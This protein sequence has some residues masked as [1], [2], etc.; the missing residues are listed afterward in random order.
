MRL[1]MVWFTLMLSRCRSAAVRPGRELSSWAK[2]CLRIETQTN[3]AVEASYSRL[4]YRSH[5]R[6]AYSSLPVERFEAMPA[7]A[8]VAVELCGREGGRDD[9][10]ELLGREAAVGGTPG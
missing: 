8:P 5:S 9:S 2:L 10:L 6:L 4:A 3:R 7:D 1:A